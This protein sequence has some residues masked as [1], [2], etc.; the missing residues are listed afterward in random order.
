MNTPN[1]LEEG[2]PIQN[3]SLDLE[4][5]TEDKIKYVIKI[6]VMGEKLTLSTSYKNG[7]IYKE[8][9]TEYDLK[10]L[11]EKTQSLAFKN[12]NE[13]YLFLKDILENNKIMKLEN[14]IKKENNSLYLNIPAKLG[15]IKEIKY[16]IKEK[17]LEEKEIQNNI[18]E[19]VN[20]LYLENEELKKQ[21]NELK[22]ENENNNKKKL[23]RIKNLFQ[24][25][26]IVKLDEKKIIN[27][28]LDPYNEKDITSEILF[29][30]NVDG[31]NSNTFHTKCNGKGPTITFIK[32][33]TGKRIGG[34]ASISWASTNGYRADPEAFIFSLDTPQKC[35]QYRNFNYAIY[36][37]SSYG[38]TFGNGHDIY[39]ANG[40]KSNSNSYCQNNYVY[41][42]FNSYNMVN[43]GA[44]QTAFQVSDYEVYLIK[45]NK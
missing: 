19:F 11:T 7:L 13:H 40:C 41:G 1:N 33:T 26:I 43:T 16:E 29:R 36:D 20:K 42:F 34:F 38:P 27:D 39:I 3:E 35:V 14:T 6:S 18:I 37:N 22:V 4:A 21:I 17:E 30:S 28:W 44:Q 32:T 45:I 31:D 10:K 9:Y 5:T 8:Y 2:K 15:I 25:S 24:D 23:E 12:I